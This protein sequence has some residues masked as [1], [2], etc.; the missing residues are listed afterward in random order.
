MSLLEIQKRK[1]IWY[2]IVDVPIVM[3]HKLYNKQAPYP[4]QHDDI[5]LLNNA[6][7]GTLKFL[8]SFTLI[9]FKNIPI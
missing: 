2:G 4:L 9:E 1:Q 3:K 5:P 8:F 6:A 7:L